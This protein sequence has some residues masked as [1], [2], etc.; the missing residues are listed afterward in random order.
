MSWKDWF[1]GR[2]LQDFMSSEE[3]A[4]VVAAIGTA[5][6]RTSGEVRV[7]I[8]M[9]CRRDPLERAARVFDRLGMRKT[10]ERN[11]VLVYC[12]LEDRKFAL[13]GDAGIHQRVGDAFWRKLA[14]DVLEQI[15]GK[16][17]SAG[18]CLAVEQIGTQLATHFPRQTDDRNE[19]T[20]QIS[21]R[22]N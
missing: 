11:G 17:L 7:H 18:L 20:D 10:M 21:F 2:Q 3:Q 19:L 15:R 22:G 9:R 5:E 8:E 6:E 1:R 14:A 12:A 16:R 13:Y 4:E